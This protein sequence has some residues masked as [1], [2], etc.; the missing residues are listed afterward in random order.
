MNKTVWIILLVIVVG[1]GAYVIGKNSNGVKNEITP[2]T[3]TT[4]QQSISQNSSAVSTVP[5]PVSSESS[6]KEVFTEQ[7]GAI[8]SITTEGNGSWQLSVDLLTLNPH[9]QPGVDTSGEFFINQN[10]QLRNLA[11]TPSTKAYS[12]GNNN[13][14]NVSMSTPTFISEI[15]TRINQ[16]NQETAQQ[17]ASQYVSY[18]F[19]IN[20][21]NISAIYEQ[22][23]P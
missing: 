16:H 12:C 11:I 5:T 7:P 19:D 17:Q 20:G 15:Q 9:W 18:Y 1:I 8:K 10:S 23:L 4:S 13:V 22:C 14:A 6:T 21:S 3:Q 2:T